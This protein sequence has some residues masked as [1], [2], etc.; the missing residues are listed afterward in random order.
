MCPQDRAG[1][2]WAT[3]WHMWPVAGRLLSTPRSNLFQPQALDL[4]GLSGCPGPREAGRMLWAARG[5]AGRCWASF[6]SSGGPCGLLRAGAAVPTGEG[7]VYTMRSHV[8]DHYILYC[9]GKFHGEQIRMMKLMGEGR[10]PRACT[11]VPLRSPVS[12]HGGEATAASSRRVLLKEALVPVPRARDSGLPPG[13]QQCEHRGRRGR[14]CIQGP[15]CHHVLRRPHD[16]RGSSS[17]RRPQHCPVGSPGGRA[18]RVQA[19]TSQLGGHGF[20]GRWFRGCRERHATSTR[21]HEAPQSLLILRGQELQPSVQWGQPGTSSVCSD[22]HRCPSICSTGATASR[23]QPVPFRPGPPGAAPRGWD[24]QPVTAPSP[25][26]V[27]PGLAGRK[28]PGAEPG[29]PGGVQGR[30]EGPRVQPGGHRQTH[31]GR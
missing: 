22:A 17:L 29:G 25:H 14:L 24:G 19:R 6:G 21:G 12:P 10:A 2:G 8:R 18:W 26:P 3:L 30:C 5:A 7:V 13:S 4:G 23:R 9:E 27:S 15:R 1:C 11:P 16:S 20:P 28:G 31:A